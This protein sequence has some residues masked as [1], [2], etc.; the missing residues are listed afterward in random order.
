LWLSV[1]QNNV[2][3]WDAVISPE[4][5]EKG[6]AKS[7]VKIQAKKA[8]S[9]QAPSSNRLPLFV[10]DHFML[11]QGIVHLSNSDTDNGAKIPIDSVTNPNLLKQ[12]KVLSLKM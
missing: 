4:K 3:N 12:H 9:A 8:A 10:L 11:D 2:S 5:Q 7:A 6:K 1:L